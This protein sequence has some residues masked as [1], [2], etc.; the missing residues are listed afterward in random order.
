MSSD[1][2]TEDIMSATYRALCKHGY[3]SVTMQDIAAESEKSK[4]ALHYH[5]ERKHD[6]LCAFLDDLLASYTDRL[7]GVEGETAHDRLLGTI[8]T[9]FEPT[10][11]SPTREFKTAILEMKAQGPYD[12]AFRERLTKF[13]QVLRDHVE[14][15]LAAGVEGGEFRADLDVEATA[16]FFATVFN[17]AQTRSVAIGRPVDRSRK[18]LEQ[19]VESR[20]LAGDYDA[21]G[22]FDVDG[23]DDDPARG[24]VGTSPEGSK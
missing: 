15:I 16:D 5:Y 23:E 14:E 3:A 7:D 4:S 17:G 11:D 18:H 21:V 6:L 8:E 2:A 19:Y 13:D 22:E 20:V 10:E 9:V 12:E 1:S 24:N